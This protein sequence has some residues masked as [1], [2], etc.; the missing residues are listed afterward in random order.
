MIQILRNNKTLSDP[1]F[2]ILQINP[3]FRLNIKNLNQ[4]LFPFHIFPIILINLLMKFFILLRFLRSLIS[5]F[6]SFQ[7]D[8]D[9]RLTMLE[10]PSKVLFD[11]SIVV[12][13]Q[14]VVF[15]LCLDFPELLVVGGSAGLQ[16]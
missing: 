14:P 6:C 5:Q 12:R 2:I 11:Q 16:I 4:L 9:Y 8:F 7:S 13:S 1:F 15:D 3:L 10:F